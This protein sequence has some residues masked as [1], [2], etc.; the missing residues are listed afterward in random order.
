MKTLLFTNWHV[1]RW[2]RLVFPY[3]YLQSLYSERMD[4]HWFGLF[5][6][7]QVIF[8]LGCGKWL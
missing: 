2:V 4:V 5:F 6:F 7:V 8:N 1:M 3:F